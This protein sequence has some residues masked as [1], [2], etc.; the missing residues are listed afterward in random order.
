[1]HINKTLVYFISSQPRANGCED[2]ISNSRKKCIQSG[3]VRDLSIFLG[4]MPRLHKKLSYE[5][6]LVWI[7][8]G[9]CRTNLHIE[10]TSHQNKSSEK[11]RKVLNN[12]TDS[13]LS[14][15]ENARDCLSF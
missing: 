8:R 11:F 12:Y 3:S 10:L 6:T 14:Q 15:K 1:M 4:Q 9:Q 13:S 2:Y 7:L 5:C